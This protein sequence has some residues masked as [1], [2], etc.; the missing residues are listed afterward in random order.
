[1]TTSLIVLGMLTLGESSPAS[2]PV[3]SLLRAVDLS[4]GESATVTLH[5]GAQISV[6]LLE[7]KE[8]RDSVMNAIQQADVT[9]EI[10][11]RHTVTLTS[12]M[13]RLPITVGGVQI[14]CPITGGYRS[15]SGEDHWGLTRDARLRLWPVGSP[16]LQPGTFVYPIR[17]RWLA[18]DTWCSNEPVSLLGGKIY[19][20]AGIDFGGAEGLTEI[21][22]ATDGLVVCA[23]DRVHGDIKDHPPVK[24][25]YDVIYI[26]DARGWYYRYS[27]LH[28]I[29]TAVQPGKTVRAGQ[30]LGLVGK[31][32]S[33]GGWAHLHFEIKSLQPSGKWGTQDSYGFLWEAYQ[34][35]YRPR[36]LAVARPRH[37]LKVGES[38]TLDGSRSWAAAG[39]RSYRWTLGDGT[40][41]DGPTAQRRYDRPGEYSEVLQVTDREGRVQYDSTVVRV[42]GSDPKV[43]GIHIAHHPT[44]GIQFGDPVTFKVRAFDAIEGV[45]RWDFGDGSPAV[46]TQSGRDP[47]QHAPDGYATT[48]HR[49]HTPG[50]Y[51]VRVERATKAGVAMAHLIVY[52]AA[53]G[54]TD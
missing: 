53:E 21:L 41:A 31:E 7:V 19:Y 15:N 46:T 2:R 12:G 30:Y 49:Y 17:Q 16:L 50:A 18:S 6:R 23:G 43:P 8:R 25:R 38:T 40:T 32:G 13:Y 3:E 20:H 5:G 28:A 48:I 26:K 11:G 24:P 42:V 37:L 29:A 47:A 27:H 51:V 34:R 54:A 4:L 22:S 45:D 52:V 33:S 39:I 10:D 44:F 35:Q 36:L 1:M 9:V 14:D